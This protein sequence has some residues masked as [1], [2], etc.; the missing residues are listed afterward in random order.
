MQLHDRGISLAL[1]RHRRATCR[2]V[3]SR[4][5]E[6][7][8]EGIMRLRVIA[9]AASVLLIIGVATLTARGR[10]E[11]AAPMKV[12]CVESQTC[13]EGAA[14]SCCVASDMQWAVVNFVDPVLVNREYVSGP[15]L[16]VHDNNKMARGEPCTTF[17]RFG[18]NE[19]PKEALVSFHCKPRQAERARKT[20]FTTEANPSG[21]KR[22]VEY[23][24]AGDSEVHG[25]PR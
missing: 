12:C 5:Q 4:P 21:V 19:G 3:G 16:I 20:T 13:C 14:E 9:A 7:C 1:L 24:I 8:Q 17:Y 18:R 23:Q 6:S 2:I 25:I 15:V 10:A 11:C 22:L